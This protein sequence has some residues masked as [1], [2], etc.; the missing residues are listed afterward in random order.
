MGRYGRGFSSS[1]AGKGKKDG[2]G[3]NGGASAMM[4]G[5]LAQTTVGMSQFATIR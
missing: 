1:A 5:Q 2:D 3:K 4:S